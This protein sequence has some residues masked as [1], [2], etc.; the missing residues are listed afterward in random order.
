V[1]SDDNAV[2]YRVLDCRQNPAKLTREL[3]TE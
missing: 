1:D 2:V 3:E